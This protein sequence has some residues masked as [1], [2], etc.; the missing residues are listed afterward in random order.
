MEGGDSSTT[1]SKAGRGPDEDLLIEIGLGDKAALEQLY[2]R[3]GP[4]L[5]SLLTRMF[6]DH[7]M[8][9]EVIQDTCL[10]V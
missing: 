6:D 9:E 10:A 5:L 7:Q 1:R 3:Q 4:S 2:R 8:A